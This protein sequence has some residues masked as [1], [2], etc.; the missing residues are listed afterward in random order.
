MKSIHKIKS[1]LPLIDL[2]F[3]SPSPP[4]GKKTN[5]RW[6]RNRLSEKCFDAAEESGFSTP[7]KE[8]NDDKEVLLEKA[9]MKRLLEVSSPPSV[10]NRLAF[11]KWRRTI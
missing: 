7:K 10:A 1:Y 2:K 6:Y 8:L 9:V 5:N 11:K 4:L 3:I